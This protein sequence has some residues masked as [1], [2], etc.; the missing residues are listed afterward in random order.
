VADVTMN[1]FGKVFAPTP[2][3]AAE[4]EAKAFEALAKLDELLAKKRFLVGDGVTEADVY[5]FHTLIR[6]DVYSAKTDA[7]HLTDFPNVEK[8]LRE[9]YQLP[10]LKSSVNWDH[11]K[12]GMVNKAP[13]LAAEGP[14]VDYDAAHNRLK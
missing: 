12:I 2:E 4:K 13:H 11:L 14:F 5:L 3:A 7:K 1:F 8:Y 10:G 9:L 6:I